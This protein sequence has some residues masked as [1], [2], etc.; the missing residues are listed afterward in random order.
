[1]KE[2]TLSILQYSRIGNI[3]PKNAVTL[4]IGLAGEGKTYTIIK[5]LNSH[6]IKPIVINLD[7]SP[8]PKELEAISLPGSCVKNLL[9]EKYTDLKDKVII[10]DTYQLMI[11]E[12]GVE[13]SEKTQKAIS[14]K[15]NKIAKTNNTTIIIIGH[16][17]DFASKEG[18]FAANKFLVRDCAEELIM[19]SKTTNRLSSK[20]ITTFFTLIKK[21]R[22]IGGTRIIDNW[23]R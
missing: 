13:D 16:S 15:L 2:P 19:T 7:E 10:I 3:I 11:D 5:F 8:I 21:G 22:G 6:E 9:E 18:I 12:L 1:M 14:R 20:N 4:V 23:M 17:E